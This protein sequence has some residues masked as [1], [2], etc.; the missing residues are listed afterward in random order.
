MPEVERP[1]LME[2]PQSRKRLVRNEERLY[3]NAPIA[4]SVSNHHLTERTKSLIAEI[5]KQDTD[6]KV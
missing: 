5:E 4:E 2:V 1:S 3:S 6:I